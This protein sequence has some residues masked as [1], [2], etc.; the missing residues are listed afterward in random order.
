MPGALFSYALMDES[1]A[2]EF[3]QEERWQKVVTAGTVLAF[4][5]C[6]SGLF[7]LAYLSTYQRIKEIGIRKVLGATV[8]QIVALL[9]GN[10]IKLVI[11]AIAIASPLAWLV[12]NHWLRNYAYHIDIGPVTFIIASA[13]AVTVT[14]AS[15]SYQSFRSALMNPVKNLR[16]E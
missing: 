11:I 9:T 16:T 13:M 7:G 15:V 6:W 5:I 2:A 3:V 1:K 12:M 10:F 4:I 8:G 14:F